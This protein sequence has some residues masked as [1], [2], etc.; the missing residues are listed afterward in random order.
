MEKNRF[1]VG[2]ILTIAISLSLV[3]PATMALSPGDDSETQ[4]YFLG[5]DELP[6]TQLRTVM[7][8][9]GIEFH[10]YYQ[11][12]IYLVKINGQPSNNA[13]VAMYAES[14]EPYAADMKISQQVMG[15]DEPTNVRVQLHDNVDVE[16][17][18]NQ[19]N[20]MGIT[21]HKINTASIN[22]IRC[23]M[24]FE[25]IIQASMFEDVKF[26][27]I[28]PEPTSFMD[29]IS[30]DT[31]MGVDTPQSFGFTGTGML[32]EV[33]DNG[34]DGA[35]PDLS[36]VIYRD[37]SVVVDHHGTCTSGIVFGNGAGDMQ[38]LGIVPDAEG[39][40]SDWSTGRATS[41]ANLW[42]GNFNEG[43]SALNGVVQSNSW[44]QGTCDGLYQLYAEEVDQ[45]MYDYPNVLTLWAAANSNDGTDEGRIS[46]DSAAKNVMC[47]GAIFH[48]D[49]A[50]LAD[51]RY[52]L[53]SQGNTPS[54]GPAADGRQKPE[55][56]APFDWIYTVDNRVGGYSGTDYYDNFGGTS[57]ATPIIAGSATIVYDMWQA[58]FFDTNPTNQLPYSSTVKAIL[59]ANA[60]Q[61]DL[62]DAT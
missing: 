9:S 49:T 6:S 51:D 28:D 53:Y 57:G 13:L 38:A 3:M 32:A 44:S 39:A 26:I 7:E 47:I 2:M 12:G 54:R 29:L 35:H 21:I 52:E 20:T 30:S 27:D 16:A 34:I 42:N 36:G 37:G 62:S 46:E 59:V 61:Y 10:G 43:N 1:H 24:D 19:L 41:I 15:I 55:M 23:A 18:V 48:Q 40:F 50:T 5:F 25:D 56:C 4:Y 14:L 11:N 8:N 58:D 60:F 17:A 22:Y 33:Q 45:A 31:Y